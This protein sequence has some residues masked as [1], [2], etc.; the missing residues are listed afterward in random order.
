MVQD[1]SYR[2]LLAKDGQKAIDLAKTHQPDLILMDI[3]MPGM[4][5]LEST[6]QIR[7]EPT[8]VDTPIIALTALAMTGDQ[9]R[10]LEAGANDYLTKPVKLK[11][12]ATTIQRLLDH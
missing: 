3:Q 5:G 2:I 10:C 7:I 1:L 8:L 6:R 12:L 4:D 9:E 11:Q